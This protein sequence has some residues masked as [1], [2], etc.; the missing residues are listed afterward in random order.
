M[1]PRHNRLHLFLIRFTDSA[2]QDPAA[3]IIKEAFET[4]L[5][6]ELA[7][8]TFNAQF[9]QQHSNSARSILGAGK[10]LRVLG[11]PTE[12]LEGTLFGVF[13][14]GVTLDIPVRQPT[15]SSDAAS[16]MSAV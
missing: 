12:E 11:S 2:T 13:N 15:V 8:E 1:F 16:A 9:L 6:P 3:P 7:S 10:G 4:L 5:P 14:E